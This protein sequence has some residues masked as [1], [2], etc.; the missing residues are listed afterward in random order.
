MS[1]R[2]EKPAARLGGGRGARLT[3]ALIL[4]AGTA[5]CTASPRY[6]INMNDRPGDG[7]LTPWQPR[8]PVS[9]QDAAQNASD[10]A[11]GS[12]IPPRNGTAYPTPPAST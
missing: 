8:Y 10:R 11:S 4:L 6:P 5:A 1:N 7:G 2:V 9:A 12:A 3:L